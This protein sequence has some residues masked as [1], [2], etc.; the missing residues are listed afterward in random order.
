MRN[1]TTS[2]QFVFEF[3]CVSLGAGAPGVAT[4]VCGTVGIV[5]A[6][7]TIGTPRITFNR[8]VLHG[9]G[10]VCFG[11]CPTSSPVDRCPLGRGPWG[12]NCVVALSTGIGRWGKGTTSR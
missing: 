10:H 8:R 5:A 1:K 3:V 7:V 6:P 2:Q 12:G 9:S 4:G 11:L